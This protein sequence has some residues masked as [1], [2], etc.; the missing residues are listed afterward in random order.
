MSSFRL[1]KHSVKEASFVENTEKEKKKNME[2]GLEGGILIPKDYDKNRHVAIKLKF[3]LGKEE[4][5]LYLTLE[6]LSTFEEEDRR[7]DASE[8]VVQRDC[9]PIALANLR[10]TLREV[11]KAYGLP[12][13]DLPPFD[14]EDIEV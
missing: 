13:L 6:T 8:E 11:T 2:V 1:K 14:E 9:L 12:A 5:R 7:V 4:E 3:H 10:K